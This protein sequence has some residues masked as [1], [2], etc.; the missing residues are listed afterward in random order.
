MKSVKMKMIEAGLWGP[1]KK[2]EPHSD[3]RDN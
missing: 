3:I 1:E 2:Q